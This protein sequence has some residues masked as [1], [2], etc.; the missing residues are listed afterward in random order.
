MSPEGYSY[1]RKNLFEERCHYMYTPYEGP[2]FLRAFL[3]TRQNI[4]D[5][6]QQ[7]STMESIPSE[8][9]AL[10]T[11]LHKHVL[12]SP[13]ATEG[14]SL[15][16]LKERVLHVLP[17]QPGA[18]LFNTNMLLVDLWQAYLCQLDSVQFCQGWL[19]LLIKKFEV[20]KRLYVAY[21]SALQPVEKDYDLLWNYALLA[22]L[23]L[24]LY[25]QKQNLKYLNTGLKLVDLLIS[26]ASTN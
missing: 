16:L 5:Q 12:T 22:A 13:Q 4:R 25:H 14:D 1:T 15:Y 3:L 11:I 24:Y 7:I 17:S 6:I 18:C 19:E 8:Y 10:I 26:V 2:Q 9:V 20:S 21:D 23:V